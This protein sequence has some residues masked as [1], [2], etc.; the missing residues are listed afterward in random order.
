MHA[1]RFTIWILRP[2]LQVSKWLVSCNFEQYCSLCLEKQVVQECLEVQRLRL[3]QVDGKML[4]KIH[5]MVDE[6]QLSWL[7]EDLQ[8]RS[9][10]HRIGRSGVWHGLCI[11]LHIRFKVAAPILV[12][13]SALFRARWL[14]F[15]RTGRQVREPLLPQL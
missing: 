9:L 3:T 10:G 2:F 15:N 12:E 1:P 5:D 6:E 11:S 7:K 14:N 13:G 4:L 8:I